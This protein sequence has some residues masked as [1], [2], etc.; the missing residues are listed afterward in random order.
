M[1]RKG[2]CYF[3]IQDRVAVR[4]VVLDRLELL[5]GLRFTVVPGRECEAFL[6]AKCWATA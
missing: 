4:L 3:Q 6:P 2:G 1:F 5:A